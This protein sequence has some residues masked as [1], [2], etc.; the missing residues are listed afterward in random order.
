MYTARKKIWKNKG[1][2]PSKFEVS[3]AQALFHV[4]KGNQELRDDLK[5]MYINTAM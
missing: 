1:V 4:K 3:V 5:D 2:K